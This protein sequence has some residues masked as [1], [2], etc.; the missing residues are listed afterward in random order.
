MA[1][2]LIDLIPARGG[3]FL[4]ESGHHGELWLDLELLC[5]PFWG[6]LIQHQVSICNLE[7]SIDDWILISGSET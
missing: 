7:Q 6:K 3:H 1:S 4:L 5:P 2:D